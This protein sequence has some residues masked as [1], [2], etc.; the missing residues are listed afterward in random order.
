MLWWGDHAGSITSGRNG[1]LLA[2][3]PPLPSNIT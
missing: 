2:D 3:L 1:T